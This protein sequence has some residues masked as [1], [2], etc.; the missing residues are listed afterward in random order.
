MILKTGVV[1]AALATCLSQVISAL[2]LLYIAVMNSMKQSRK[3]ID[4]DNR[5]DSD[6]DVNVD[7]DCLNRPAIINTN[8]NDGDTSDINK[9]RRRRGSRWDVCSDSWHVPTRPSLLAIL[10]I[11][12]TYFVLPSY[13]EICSYLHFSSSLFIILFIKTFL[14]TFTTYACS[15]SGVVALA[16]HQVMI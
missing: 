13:T 9:R 1:G 3:E 14:W 7:R 12:K 16:A 4:C 10:T 2:Y 6:V 8:M 11:M 15:V 5:D